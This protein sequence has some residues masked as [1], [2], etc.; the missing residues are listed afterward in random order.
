MS[1]TLEKSHREI[2]SA[3]LIS[4]LKMKK[5]NSE[6]D[7]IKARVLRKSVILYDRFNKVAE[8][9]TKVTESKLR[10]LYKF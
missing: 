4:S 9:L 3:N 2:K 7:E 1:I 10:I 5:Q 8:E 6:E